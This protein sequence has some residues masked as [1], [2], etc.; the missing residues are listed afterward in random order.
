MQTLITDSVYMQLF[1]QQ[2][3][4]LNTSND[5]GLPVPEQAGILQFKR[6]FCHNKFSHCGFH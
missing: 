3:M 2:K 5:S 6:F 4:F 1:F